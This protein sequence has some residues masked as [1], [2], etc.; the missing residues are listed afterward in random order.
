MRNLKL[1]NHW[2]AELRELA[3]ERL[4]ANYNKTWIRRNLGIDNFKEA[5]Q[6]GETPEDAL[7]NELDYWE[8]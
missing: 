4:K 1:L 6:N 3:F 2:I 5:F 7:D 8:E